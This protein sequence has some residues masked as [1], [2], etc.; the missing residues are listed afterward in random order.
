M[1]GPERPEPSTA[2][3]FAVGSGKSPANDV[4]LRRSLSF[5]SRSPSCSPASFIITFRFLK[6]PNPEFCQTFEER[7]AGVLLSLLAKVQAARSPPPSRLVSR[8]R[9]QSGRLPD[10][11]RASQDED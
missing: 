9:S 4:D 6:R 7:T 2:T 3:N 10:V 8:P 5:T 1:N 11:G